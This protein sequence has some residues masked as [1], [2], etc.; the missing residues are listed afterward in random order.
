MRVGL[1]LAALG[2]VG[3]AVWLWMFDG[4]FWLERWAAEGQRAAQNGMAR[5]LR[6]LR[7][8]EPGALLTLMA[9]CF[10]YG[11]FHAV[12]P[13]HGKLLIS[14][15]G[16]AK[17]VALTRLSVLAVLSS[18]AQAG[19]AIVLVYGGVW[20]FGLGREA[21]VGAAEDWFAPVSYAAIGAIGVWLALR[22]AVKLWTLRKAPAEAHHDHD[23]D[24]D[25][26]D[27]VCSSCGH[28]HGPTP[29]QAAHIRSL[30]DALM[31]IGAIAIRPC[32]GALFLL[33]LAIRMDIDLAGILG[34]LAMGLGTASVTV[35]AA[36]ASV[37]F[38]E[39]TM[40][41]LAGGP[42]AVR[43]MGLI[44]TGAGLIIATLAAQFL[45]RAL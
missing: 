39:G 44:E 40:A 28:A 22:G 29:D 33:I 14:G 11:F 30:R 6:A 10:G 1:Q 4:A 3:L 38:R 19:T 35:A 31:L 2:I 26:A 34:T 5:G 27:G 16:V 41:R 12:G 36:V 20:L 7:A 15:Y 8:Q 42:Q 32:T 17:R 45:M 37:T 9:V 24:H 13:G 43:V 21:M 25:H 23:H 18:L